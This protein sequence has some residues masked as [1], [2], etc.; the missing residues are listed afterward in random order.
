MLR[1]L[2]IIHHYWPVRSFLKNL[3]MVALWWSL[4]YLVISLDKKESV[5][6]GVSLIFA[7]LATSLISTAVVNLKFVRCKKLWRFLWV[8]PIPEL[9]RL[10]LIIHSYLTN[11]ISWRG[12]KFLLNTDGTMSLVVTPGGLS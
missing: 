6:I 3:V 1:W 4:L 5:Y 7:V 12:R 11:K 10:P 9:T 2:V 8:V